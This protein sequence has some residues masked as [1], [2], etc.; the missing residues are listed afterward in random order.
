MITDKDK[1]E[2][3]RLRQD[4]PQKWTYVAL[5]NLYGVTKQRIAYIINPSA[6]YDRRYP[7][8]RRISRQLWYQ[9]RKQNDARESEGEL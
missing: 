5:G 7:E 4:D 2:I 8:R 6:T 3:I 1:A 9:R